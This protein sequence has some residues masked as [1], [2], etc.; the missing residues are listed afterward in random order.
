MNTILNVISYFSSLASQTL[1]VQQTI[2]MIVPKDNTI[3]LSLSI[4][5]ISGER[6]A[7]PKTTCP[8][9]SKMLD[10]LSNWLMVNF[11]FLFRSQLFISVYDNLE[12]VYVS[13]GGELLELA[14][15]LR[16]KQ[17]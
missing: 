15:G 7:T 6:I 1:V 14:T 17:K 9:L 13:S 2:T 5:A 11:G 16:K 4:P 12:F 10:N 3:E 8:A